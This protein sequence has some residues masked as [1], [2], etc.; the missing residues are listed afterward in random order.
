MVVTLSGVGCYYRRSGCACLIW[1]QLSN[2]LCLLCSYICLVLI[3][4]VTRVAAVVMVPFS[5]HRIVKL[6]V[7]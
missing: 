2:L 7:R 1:Q 6:T 5:S 4:A 3:M